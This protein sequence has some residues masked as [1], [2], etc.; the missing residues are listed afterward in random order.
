MNFFEISQRMEN[1]K[2]T[3]EYDVKHKKVFQKAWLRS[4][5]ISNGRYGCIAVGPFICNKGHLTVLRI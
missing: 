5:G 4:H 3:Y 1:G 2:H